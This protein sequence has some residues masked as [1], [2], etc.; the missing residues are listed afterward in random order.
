MTLKQR[1]TLVD[2]ALTEGVGGNIIGKLLRKKHNINYLLVESPLMTNVA[3]D[4]IPHPLEGE[5]QGATELPCPSEG[6]ARGATL[7]SGLSPI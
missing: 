3:E 4:D 1:K 7:G 6:G 5:K 2:S